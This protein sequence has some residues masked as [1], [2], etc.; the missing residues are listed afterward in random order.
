MRGRG[1][2]GHLDPRGQRGPAVVSLP[3]SWRYRGQAGDL[4]AR[5]EH[6]SSAGREG[7]W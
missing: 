1:R 6:P 5:Q 2:P 7:A 4:V 3:V